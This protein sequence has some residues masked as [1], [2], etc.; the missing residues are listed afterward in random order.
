MFYVNLAVLGLKAEHKRNKGPEAMKKGALDTRQI[1]NV[2]VQG[3]MDFVTPTSNPGPSPGPMPISPYGQFNSMIITITAP[4]MPPHPGVTFIRNNAQ[5]KR[6][7][8]QPESMRGTG[9][10][11]CKHAKPRPTLEYERYWSNHM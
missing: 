10:T 7:H 6:N 9:P 5:T 8:V 3:G 2:G 11:T 1:M 4:T